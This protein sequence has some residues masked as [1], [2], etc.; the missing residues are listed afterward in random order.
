MTGD[1]EGGSAWCPVE[2][3]EGVRSGGRVGSRVE[4]RAL[5]SRPSWPPASGVSA[6]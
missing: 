4:A 5:K 3:S 2:E 1:C 6:R